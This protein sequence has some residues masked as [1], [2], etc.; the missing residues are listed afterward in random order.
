MTPGDIGL[1]MTNMMTSTT[2]N[3][4]V[5]MMTTQANTCLVKSTKKS[6]MATTGQTI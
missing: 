4:V 6:T 3:L 2:M 1:T 5:T